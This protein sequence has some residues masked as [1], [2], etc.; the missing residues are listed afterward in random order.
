MFQNQPEIATG[1]SAD[2]TDTYSFIQA[3]YTYSVQAP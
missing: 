2:Y 1:T 3:E